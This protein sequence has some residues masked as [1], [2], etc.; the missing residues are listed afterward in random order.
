MTTPPPMIDTDH[1]LDITLHH[2]QQQ[3]YASNTR[4]TALISGIQGGKTRIGGLWMTRQIALYSGPQQ[5]FIIAGPNYKLMEKSTIPWFMHLNKDFGTLDKAKYR[6]TL[7]DG[8][9]V[10]FASMQDDD[11]VEGAT[12][13]R[14]ILIDEAGKIREKSWHNLIARSSFRQ[15]P[16][17]ITTTPYAMNWLYHQV[18]LPWKKKERS[19]ITVIQFRSCDN[20]YFPKEEY[21]N[22]KRVLDPRVFER[23]YGGT[24]TRMAGLV[25]PEFGPDNLIQPFKPD[26]SKHFICAGVD[27]GYENPF[28]ISIRAIARDGT[29]DFQIAEFYKSFMDP[30]QRTNVLLQLKQVYN[31]EQF[32]IDSAHPDQ[33]SLFQSAGLPAVPVEKG[34]G[35]IQHGISLH[36]ELI[37]SATYQV[38]EDRCPNT[39]AEYETY[40]YPED[41]DNREC[42]A[43]ENPV[44]M[45]DHLMDANRYTTMMTMG[46]RLK[47]KED[48]K[49]IPAKSH[50]ELLN[51]G[52]YSN[53]NNDDWYNH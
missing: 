23:K 8:G 38:I 43:S 31:I 4:L 20:P 14:S 30:V 49:F 27:I 13:V 46:I 40:H 52:F 15:C 34:P 45:N 22:Q 41:Q 3:A 6:F 44:P 48:N 29:K 47:A 53:R 37:R 17:F 25:Y 39:I 28:A 26:I 18:Y 12:N 35:S 9:T 36:A 50:L 21:E 7:H 42:N 10:W 16:I 2:H 1:V 33:I 19:D 51:E 5:V 11:S 24:F 32:Y